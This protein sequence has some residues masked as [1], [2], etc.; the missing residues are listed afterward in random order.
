[1]RISR[2]CSEQNDFNNYRSQIKSWFLKSECPEKLIENEIRN[3]KFCKKGIKK[4]KGVKG[5]PFVVTCHPQ[6]KN[7]GRIINQNFYLL[8]MNEETKKLFSPRTMVSFRSPR[9]I[10]SYLVRAKL[11]PLER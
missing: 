7:L 3:I 6:L 9:K 4:A 5:I 2:L 8:N 10:I 11:Y 1:M